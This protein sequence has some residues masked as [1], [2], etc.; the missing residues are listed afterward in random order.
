MQDESPNNSAAF[1]TESQ[2]ATEATKASSIETQAETGATNSPTAA[3]ILPDTET[4]SQKNAIRKAKSYLN[5]SAFSYQGLV[6]QLE[7]EKF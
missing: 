4:V 1:S 6:K 7:Y 3:P 5:Y 2:A